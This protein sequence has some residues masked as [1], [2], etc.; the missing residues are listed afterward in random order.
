MLEVHL[1]NNCRFLVRKLFVILTFCTATGTHAQAPDL[2]AQVWIEPGQTATQ[3]DGWFATLEAAHMRLARLFVMW[4]YVQP[5]RT[6]WDF[7]LYD[8]AFQAAGSH[9]VRIIATLTPSGLPVFLGGDG[10]QGQGIAKSKIQELAAE[11]YMRRV[12]RRYRSSRALDSWIL[13]NE[14]GQ[15]PMDTPSAEDAFRRWSEERYG[16]L[17]AINRGWGTGFASLSAVSSDASGNAWNPKRQIDWL[18]FWRDFQSQTLQTMATVVRREDPQHGVH[19]NPHALLSNL[20]GLSDDLPQWRGFLDT[21]GCSIHPAWHFGLLKEDQFALGVSYINDLVDGSISPKPHWVTELQGGNNIASGLKP[22][23]PTPEQIAQ[24]TWT[25]IGAGAQRVIYW[26]LNARSEGTEAAEWSMLD[27]HQQPSE[28][29]RTAAAIA[30]TTEKNA[31]AFRHTE[32]ARPDVTLIV[33]LET[34]AYELTTAKSDYPGRDRNAQLLETLGIYAAL[35]RLGPPPA[36]K[37]FDD[38]Q[39]EERSPKART[40]ILPDIRS[41]TELQIARL[42]R[43]AEHGNV[44]LITGLTGFYDAQGKAWPLAGFPLASL[45][46]GRLKEVKFVGQ[47]FNQNL[48]GA[49]SALPVHL[50]SSS[51]EV[52]HGKILGMRDGEVSAMESRVKGGGKVIW[53]PSLIGLGAWLDNE[54][55][56]AD[57]LNTVLQPAY[58][59][60]PFRFRDTEHSCLLR[61]LRDDRGKYLTVVTNGA[62]SPTNCTLH[63]VG[64]EIPKILWGD[65]PVIHGAEARFSLKPTGTSVL[66]WSK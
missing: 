27:F 11:E 41:L 8:A 64:D 28:R 2:G 43:F 1:A 26:L 4:P 47:F 60:F 63:T 40:A 10:T 21:L 14:P 36:I 33:S 3:I 39:W 24:W 19:L 53:V 5:N 58:D 7:T 25:S 62:T 55:P 66:L 22:L 50:W 42:V 16:S 54:R 6:T 35:A 31:D 59:G 51:I 46:G 38:Y 29:L 56:L 18:S 49:D 44:V 37:H 15:A 23:N 34:M 13:L 32:V 30:E 57:F 52:D 17:A 9:H 48:A 12:V 20:A 65:A 61:V 45:T